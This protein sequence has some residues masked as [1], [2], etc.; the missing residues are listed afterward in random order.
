MIRCNNF[1]P[2]KNYFQFFTIVNNN[3]YPNVDIYFF[4]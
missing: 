2:L 1:I 4:R 3:K